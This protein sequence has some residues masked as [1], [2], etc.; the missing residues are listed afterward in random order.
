MHISLEELARE[1]GVHTST[2]QRWEAGE[3]LPRA[4]R[5]PQIARLLKIPE[6]VLRTAWEKAKRPERLPNATR[7]LIGSAE[8]LNSGSRAASEG[9]QFRVVRK[10]H[11][12]GLVREA[13]KVENLLETPGVVESDEEEVQEGAP[14]RVKS[15]KKKPTKRKVGKKKA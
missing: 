8:R 2:P 11:L 1:L 3:T 15:V 7:V 10:A 5:I 9:A 12:A 4:S 14:L 13:R 6:D